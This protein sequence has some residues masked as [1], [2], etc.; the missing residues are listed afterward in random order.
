MCFDKI[1]WSNAWI[2]FSQPPQRCIQAGKH[3][4]RQTVGRHTPP[5]LP[6][7]SQGRYAYAGCR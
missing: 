7:G 6:K 1:L 5:Q 3:G 4:R 2:R